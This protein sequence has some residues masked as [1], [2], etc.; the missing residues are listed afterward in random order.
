MLVGVAITVSVGFLYLVILDMQHDAW[1]KS[2][3]ERAE[4]QVNRLVDE[5][6]LHMLFRQY[7]RDS[8]YH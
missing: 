8:F 5:L 2:Q 6:K 1:L 4:V 3:T 7:N